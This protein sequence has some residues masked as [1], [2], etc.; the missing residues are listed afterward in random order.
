[1]RKLQVMMMTVLVLILSTA[2][3]FA[4]QDT[5]METALQEFL[6]Y[7]RDDVLNGTDILHEH[8]ETADDRYSFSISDSA[9]IANR[10]CYV[11]NIS[12]RT[13]NWNG[14]GIL[15]IETGEW[16]IPPTDCDSLYP[17]PSGRF[18]LVSN[19]Y[20][21]DT[22]TCA[23]ADAEGNIT[24]AE[25]PLSG[26]V[27][28]V[29]DEGYITL[30]RRE[31]LPLSETVFTNR[32]NVDN[33]EINRLAL[34]NEDM[35]IILDFVVDGS[36]QENTIDFYDDRAM[37]RTGSTLWTGSIK[38]GAEGNGLCG[39]IDRSGQY[40][41]AHDFDNIDYSFGRWFG[42]RGEDTYLLD[43]NGGERLL[44]ADYSGGC[45]NWAKTE[46]ESAEQHNLLP[47][48]MPTYYT[49][50]IQR[51]E[52]CALAMQLYSVLGGVPPEDTD[53]TAFSDCGDGTDQ[54]V[55]QAAALGIVNGYADGTFRPR[56]SITRQEAA[57]MLGRVYALLGRDDVSTEYTAYADDVRIAEWAKLYV[58]QMQAVGV[59]K[60]VE[61]N[62]FQ[63][64]GNYTIEQ[65][66]VTM[67]RLYNALHC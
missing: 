7:Y 23:Y 14:Y 3:G 9:D 2:S 60:G 61:N 63:P 24:P 53:G 37:I 62:L 54:S 8:Y 44:P 19:D 50:D 30:G 65:A 27:F 40:V 26:L 38:Y 56:A 13:N 51:E 29:D 6:S 64:E 67:E 45:S 22:S 32:P 46:M 49:L 25:M 21:T 17:L 41:G 16:I 5:G 18:L 59:M 31:M 66:V 15:D 39:L 36:T 33:A 57:A 52:F 12:D 58:Y 1:M 10:S 48:D 28:G 42:T 20:G 55:Y 35:E 47:N 11:V 43:G 34:L 4:A